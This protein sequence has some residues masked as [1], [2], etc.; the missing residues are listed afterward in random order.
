MRESPRLSWLPLVLFVLGLLLLVFNEAGYLAP[1]EYVFHY[2]LDPLQRAFSGVVVIT[3]KAQVVK[4]AADG[5]IVPAREKQFTAIPYY[6]WA[7]RGRGQMTVWPARKP[8]AARPE[9]A[10]TMQ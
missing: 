6:A 7:H 2:V 9:P 5:S 10:D 3:G 8:H 1:V 4:R